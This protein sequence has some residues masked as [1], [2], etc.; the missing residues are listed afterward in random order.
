MVQFSGLIKMKHM[1]AGLLASKCSQ[2][3]KSIADIGNHR[4]HTSVV[5]YDG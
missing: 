4:T 2:T 3:I 1:T 5:V